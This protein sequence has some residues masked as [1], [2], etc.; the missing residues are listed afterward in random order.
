MTTTV[1]T[2]VT[3]AL[4]DLNLIGA[5]ETPDA[6][7]AAKALAQLNSLALGWTADNIHTGWST[8][9][10]SDDFPLEA[11][12]EEGVVYLLMEKIAGSRGQPLTAEQRKNAEKGLARL[13]AD[14]KA[15]ETLRVDDALQFMP[16]QRRYV[17]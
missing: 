10:L 2:I 7:E 14:F 15:L 8:V 17:W 9:E 11:K 6:S 4:R 3:R 16:S 12:H 13:M 1:R 5:D